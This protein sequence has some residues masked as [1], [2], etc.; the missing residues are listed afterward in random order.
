MPHFLDYERV[1]HHKS[2][3]ADRKRTESFRKAIRKVVKKGDVVAD[4]GA[5]TGILS[6][7]AAQAG[8]SKVYAIERTGMANVAKRLAKK[9]GFEKIEVISRDS[10]NVNLPEKCD[11]IVSECIGYFVLQ[12]NMISDVIDFRKR[13]LKDGGRMIPKKVSLYLAPVS[14]TAYEEVKFWERVYGMDF[15]SMKDIAANSSYSKEIKKFELL[16]EPKMIKRVD[17]HKDRNMSL[18][19]TATFIAQ[20]SGLL[21]GLCG[22]F[23]TEL[24]NDVELSNTPGSMTHWK[25]QY[26]PLKNPINV[27]TGYNIETNIHA[28]MQKAMIDWEWTVETD[29]C[30]SYQS[31]TKGIRLKEQ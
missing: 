11:V 4:L 6:F 8:A 16:A 2:M 28:I 23:S 9:N 17:M 10:A 20:K 18:N 26:F 7:F 24:C 30:I 29:G 31:T 1:N 21:N 27:L 15:D 5:G 25:Q 13:N 22:Y 3:L 19:E 12:E 14:S